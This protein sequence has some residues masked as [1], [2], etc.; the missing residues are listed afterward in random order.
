MLT[1]TWSPPLCSFIIKGVFAVSPTA[2]PTQ[3]LA[4]R[5]VLTR[6]FSTCRSR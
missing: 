4:Q 6:V 5:P 1:S 3:S 2:R